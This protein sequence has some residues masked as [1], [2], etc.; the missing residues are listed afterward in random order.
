MNQ[1]SLMTMFVTVMALLAILAAPPARADD[2][3]I[4]VTGIGVAKAKPTQVEIGARLSG[5]GELAADASVKFNDLKKKAVAALEGLKDPNLSLQ[6]VGQTV[7][8]AADPAA[9]MRQMQGQAVEAKQRVAISEQVRLVIK[10][11]DKLDPEKAVANVLKVLDTAKDCGLQIGDP[12]GNYYQMQMRAQSGQSDAIVL[13]KIPDKS[14]LESKAYEKA[15]ADAKAKAERIAKL[16]GVKVGRV[17][18]VQDLGAPGE[19]SSPS[20]IIAAMYN[21]AA[22]AAAATSTDAK[23]IESATLS[24]IPV[25]IRL[26]VRFEIEK[27]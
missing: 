18:A 27:P 9:Q 10:G 5:E 20:A 7:G 4:S 21:G 1:R 12:P 16:N 14:E 15:V 26:T 25:S 22:A 24:E 13:F 17:L 6:F 2:S 11:I 3:G 8:L 19:P 23:E